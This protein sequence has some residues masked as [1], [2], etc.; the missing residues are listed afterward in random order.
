MFKHLSI[1]TQVLLLIGFVFL[2]GFFFT[3]LYYSYSYGDEVDAIIS[4]KVDEVKSIFKIEAETTTD[5]LSATLEVILRDKEMTR[6]FIEGKRGELY[7]YGTP[8]YES[9]RAGFGVTHIYF[10]MPDGKNFLRFHNK[11]FNGDIIERDTLNRSRESAGE[12]SGFEIGETSVAL[13]VVAP[14]YSGGEIKGYVEIAQD[15]EFFID[16]MVKDFGGDYAVSLEKSFVNK[17]RWAEYAKHMEQPFDWDFSEH[18]VWSNRDLRL[19]GSGDCFTET[20]ILRYGGDNDDFAIKMGGNLCGALSLMESAGSKRHFGEFFFFVS[21]AKEI[22]HADNMRVTLFIALLAPFA[23]TSFFLWLLIRQSIA[24]PV[25]MLAGVA[26]R[27]SDGDFSDRIDVRSMDEIGLLGAA[28]NEMADQLEHYRVEMEDLVEKRTSAL[29]SANNELLGA[30]REVRGAYIRLE[31]QTA[32]LEGAYNELEGLNEELQSLE[33][34]KIEFLQT[35]SHEL[36]SPLTPILGYLEIMR[37]GD[38]G[39]LT[40]MQIGI[41]QEMLIS[42]RNLQM[43]MDELLESASLQAG[44]LYLE[45]TTVDMKKIFEHILEDLNK[46]ADEAEIHIDVDMPEEE[47]LLTGDKKRLYEIFNHL[48]RNAVKFSKREGRISVRAL[49]L[50]DGVEVTIADRGIGIADDKLNLIFEAFY[51]VDSS[52]A[53]FY[54]GVG[55]GLFLVKKLVDAH[56]GTV[57]V[58]SKEEEGTTFK[59][60]IPFTHNEK[61]R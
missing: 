55:L 49:R 41:I 5:I 58:S 54:E 50:P 57:A 61:G 1:G 39:E 23:V 45:L 14:L 48:L 19:P 3:Y 28:M 24:V 37:D 35:L 25:R 42:S 27:I 46:Y 9:F 15:V 7:R 34:L 22:A 56:N 51:Q 26:S 43:V 36:R 18:H 32:E 60:F 52:S 4:E 44:R 11:A 8:L 17:E 31:K 40:E 16:K 30:N 20:N 2:G 38:A 6:L 12:V 53:R 29:M 13:R 47:L 10:H 21:M 59:V 33:K